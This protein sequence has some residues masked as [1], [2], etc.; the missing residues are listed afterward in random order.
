MPTTSRLKIDDEFTDRP[1]SRRRRWQL[2]R[3]LEG[4]CMLC[5]A[6]AEGKLCDAHAMAL[7][8]KQLEARQAKGVTQGKRGRWLVKAGLR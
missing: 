1:V 7:A 8:L 6:T 5:G 2:R 4:R 3:A